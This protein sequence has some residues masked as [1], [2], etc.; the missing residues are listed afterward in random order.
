MS[1]K[2]KFKTDLNQTLQRVSLREAIAFIS[3]SILGALVWIIIDLNR[4]KMVKT[5]Q[6]L[7]VENGVFLLVSWITLYTLMM[8]VP[9]ALIYRKTGN[10]GTDERDEA[11]FRKTA[12]NGFFITQGLTGLALFWYVHHNDGLLLFNSLLVGIVASS[13]L[14]FIIL[15]VR[16]RAISP[17]LLSEAED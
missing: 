10:D 12:A 4:E 15:A 14:F 11:I 8:F 9:I 2:S 5:G 16:Y 17:P 1:S 6:W 7:P 13:S 3:G